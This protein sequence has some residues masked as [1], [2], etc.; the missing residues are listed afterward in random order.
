MIDLAQASLVVIHCD[1]SKDVHYFS[2]GVIVVVIATEAHDDHAPNIKVIANV[3]TPP[4]DGNGARQEAINQLLGKIVTLLHV[5]YRDMEHTAE[6]RELGRWRRSETKAPWKRLYTGVS[7][8]ADVKANAR[9]LHC[10]EM[11]A[12]TIPPMGPN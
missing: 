3:W 7:G 8:T 10:V 2:R 1:G 9:G 5:L 12:E 6:H 11:L 4:I